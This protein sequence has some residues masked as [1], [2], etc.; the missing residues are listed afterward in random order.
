V[1]SRFVRSHWSRGGAPA[2]S[3]AS[4]SA[5][6]KTGRRVPSRTGRGVRPLDA[7]LNQS[8]RLIP[9]RSQGL[10]VASG[11]SETMEGFIGSMP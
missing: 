11:L 9:H 2:L 6:R 5:M 7:S 4:S 10:A 8:A 3:Q 1:P